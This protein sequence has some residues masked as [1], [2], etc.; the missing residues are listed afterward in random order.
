MRE[1]ALVMLVCQKFSGT[2]CKNKSLKI[3]I[4]VN[5]QNEKL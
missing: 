1:I 3:L 5:Y 4:N 2:V